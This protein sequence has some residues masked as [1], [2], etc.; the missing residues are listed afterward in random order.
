MTFTQMLR[1][2]KYVVEA[3]EQRLRRSWSK[4]PLSIGDFMPFDNLNDLLAAQM[5]IQHL[6][7]AHNFPM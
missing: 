2:P 1:L 4:D 7:I 5:L 6:E 3:D